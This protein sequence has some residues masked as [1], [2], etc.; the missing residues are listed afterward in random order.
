MGRIGLFFRTNRPVWCHTKIERGRSSR[1][2]S[3]RSFPIRVSA[4]GSSHGEGSAHGLTPLVPTDGGVGREAGEQWTGGRW[5][6]HVDRVSRSH[7]P[8]PLSARICGRMGVKRPEK[9][10]KWQLWGEH[11]TYLQTA[12]HLFKYAVMAKVAAHESQEKN[13]RKTISYNNLQRKSSAPNIFKQPDNVAFHSIL[14]SCR[15]GSA[16]TSSAPARAADLDDS[17]RSY[18]TNN[19]CR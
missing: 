17:P 5:S 3:V 18:S 6:T 16:G 4:S 14:T 19:L 7:S 15:V 11:A 2:D 9:G 13:R 1:S 8:L 10:S 12:Q